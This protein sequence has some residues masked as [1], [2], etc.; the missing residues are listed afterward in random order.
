MTNVKHVVFDLDGTLLDTTV[1][2]EKALTKTIS[3]F[4][5]KK[6]SSH[7]IKSFIGPPIK[8]TLELYYNLSGDDLKSAVDYF[9]KVYS[10]D[11]LFHA[12]VYSGVYEM[13]QSLNI[14]NIS[15]S[16]ATYKREDYAIKLFE[17]FRFNA[18]TDIVFGADNDNVLTKKEII[19]KCITRAKVFDNSQIIMVGD[20]IHDYNGALELGI[21]FIPVT[22]GFGFNESDNFDGFKLAGI[23]NKPND[24]INF[25][26]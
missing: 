11:Y 9:R 1:G 10:E 14:A 24:L 3:E 8:N 21:N 7:I 2:I 6:T 12:K 13:F 4:K 17:Y 20:T 19:L 5:L 23:V 26:R 22:Y 15:C 16:I 18:Y 25:L